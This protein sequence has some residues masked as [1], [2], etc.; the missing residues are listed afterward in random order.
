MPSSNCALASPLAAS[1]LSAAMRSA[2]APSPDC[3]H[4]LVTHNS[5]LRT[6][7]KRKDR[8]LM[9]CASRLFSL[10]NSMTKNPHDLD[11]VFEAHLVA[12]QYLQ[13]SRNRVGVRQK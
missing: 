5:S 9:P 8:I 11:K 3:A 13:A 6:A 12:N 7:H 10:L 4:V 1:F 2:V